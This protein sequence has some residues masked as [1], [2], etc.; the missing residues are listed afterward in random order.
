MLCMPARSGEDVSGLALVLYGPEARE[1]VVQIALQL[2]LAIHRGR[3]LTSG[4]FE[5]GAQHIF[6]STRCLEEFRRFFQLLFQPRRLGVERILG[7]IMLVQG[8]LQ[9]RL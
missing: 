2:L 3:M 9:L 5:L 7:L 1:S 8:P 6:S 4:V